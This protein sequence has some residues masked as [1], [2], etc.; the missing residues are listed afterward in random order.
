MKKL[1]ALPLAALAF[2]AACDDS[3]KGLLEPQGPNFD[4]I[5]VEASSSLDAVSKTMSLKVGGSNGTTTLY[6]TPTGEGKNPA[7]GKSGCNLT[8]GTTLVVSVTSNSTA[9]ATV[10]PSSVT[11][12][13]CSDKELLTVTPVGEGTTTIN[14]GQTSN[15]TGATFDFTPATFTVNVAARTITN[16]PPKISISG[17][18]EAARYEMATVPAATCSVTDTEDGS[19]SFPATL[20]A[21]TGPLALYGAG[22]QTATCTYTDAG[23]VKVEDDVTYEIYD[24]RAPVISGDN[25][26]ITTWSNAAVS[27]SFTASDPTPGTGFNADQG[28]DANGGFTL[29]ASAQSEDANTPTTVSKT[30]TD[31]A[32]NV[33]A[34]RT[35]SALID[36]TKP[37]VSVTG[38][39]NGAQYILGSEPTA[40]CSTTDALSG[41]ATHASVSRSGG[42]VGSVTVTC[43]GAV[44]NAGNPGSASV[45]YHVVYAFDGFFRPID[46]TATNRVKAGSAVPIKFSLGGDQGLSIFAAGS[47]SSARLSTCDGSDISNVTETVTA[48]GSSLQYDAV[49]GQYI[50]VW[51][52]DASWAGTCRQLTVALNDGRTVKVVKFNFTK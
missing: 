34:T 4:D 48:G 30:V 26:S 14:L 37:V 23:G 8:G 27:R 10:S 32:G 52:T 13:S 46:N 5:G 18:S 45:T 33:S 19:S 44:D 25:V 1:Y 39:S 31:R 15:N 17:V 35:L 9:V 28:L 47:P 49:A 42:S 12:D 6:V 29:T 36:L 50:Y 3:S 11:F 38:A 43:N 16:N 20:S 2:T 40:G 22:N 51:K 7:D 24:G 21:I 41:V